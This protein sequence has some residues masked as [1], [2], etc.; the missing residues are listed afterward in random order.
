EIVDP[1]HAIPRAIPLALGITLL[2]YALVAISAL[3]TIEGAVLAQSSAPLVAAVESGRWAAMS[4]VVRVG[5]V[6]AS[7][8]VLLSLLAGVS[9]TAFA[10]A[11]NGDLPA[12]LAAVH[13]RYR[14]PHHAELVVG[15]LVCVIVAIADVRDAIGFSSF[16]VLTY[17]AIANAAALTLDARELRW[18]R[19]LAMCGI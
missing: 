5:A 2:A 1:A 14:V 3:L 8:G 16:A 19:G 7:L 15:V 17:Y 10:M 18:P 4:S 11:S 13:P 6:A 9:R 12:F